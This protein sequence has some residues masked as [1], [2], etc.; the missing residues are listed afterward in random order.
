MEDGPVRP[1]LTIRVL[2]MLIQHNTHNSEA[3]A[4]LQ[5]TA[6]QICGLLRRVATRHRGMKEPG[7]CRLIEDFLISGIVYSFPYYHLRLSDKGEIN[8][9][10]RMAYRSALGLPRYASSERLL[11]LGIFDELIEAHK[12]AQLARLSST[13]AGRSVLNRLGMNPVMDSAGR[14]SLPQMIRRQLVLK[15]L[16]KNMP[17]GRHDGRR[18][19]RAKDL[20]EKYKTNQFVTGPNAKCL[21]REGYTNP[22]QTMPSPEQ[23]PPLEDGRRQQCEKS[24]G[25]LQD[26]EKIEV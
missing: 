21:F 3:I 11:E 6:R 25:P 13:D 17:P 22:P 18:S 24:L 19:A 4:R 5:A 26:I 23:Y 16:P 14:T 20:H 9:I 15:P 2:G 8:G 12:T 7:L 10:I 1:V